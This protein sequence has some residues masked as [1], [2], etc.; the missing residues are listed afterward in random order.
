MKIWCRICDSESPESQERL[1]EIARLGLARFLVIARKARV[2]VTME[3][4]RAIYSQRFYTWD[5]VGMPTEVDLLIHEYARPGGMQRQF[6]HGCREKVDRGIGV[7]ARLE[8][9][10][11]RKARHGTF[12]QNTALR[13]SWNRCFTGRRR[14]R[15][16]PG[17]PLAAEM[18]KQYRAGR[19][20]Q[21]DLR[22]DAVDPEGGDID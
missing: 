15:T 13:T 19:D 11:A 21:P 12:P 7:H 8:C 18:L 22:N 9:E 2:P 14:V 17:N 16:L 4:Q 1:R 20:G 6:Q 3:Q 10:L 5:C